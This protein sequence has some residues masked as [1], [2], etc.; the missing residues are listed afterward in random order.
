MGSW[1]D[2]EPSPIYGLGNNY[3]AYYVSW[4]DAQNFTTALNTHITNTGQ[5][6]ATVRLPSEA[7][8]EYACRAGTTTRFYFGDS[9]VCG[10]VCEDCAAGVLPGNRSDYMWYCGNSSI[11]MPVGEK[12]PNAF[13]LYDMCGNVREYCEDDW[14]DTYDGVSSNS[15]A[16][17]GSP[18]GASR[19][20]RGDR[21]NSHGYA[22]RTAFRSYSL[23]SA[24]YYNM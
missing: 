9:L 23:P 17:I 11:S 7:E 5:E 6:P 19:V 2:T 4:N 13:G 18:R 8:W 1:P 21:W 24:T 14:H 12:L 15:E 20:D 22:C 10:A 16:W 3:P